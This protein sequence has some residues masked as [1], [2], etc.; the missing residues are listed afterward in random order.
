MSLD[1]Y[2][3]SIGDSG[4]N[5]FVPYLTAGLDG[6]RECLQAAAEAGADAVEVGIPFSDPVMDGPTIQQASDRSL[7][8]GTTPD[9]VIAELARL[10]LPVPAIVMT[11]TNI[12]FHMGYDRFAGSLANAGVG[13][14][15]LADLPLNEAKPWCEA[16]DSADIATI[17]LAA[18][19]SSEDR[20]RAIAER[21]RGFIYAVGLLGVTGERERLADS[22]TVVVSRL[23]AVTDKPVFVGVGISNPD[24]AA[25]ASKVA[26]GV[27]VGSVLVRKMLEGASPED[28]GYLV[29]EF[30]MVLD[31]YGGHAF[32]EKLQW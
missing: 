19:T 16:A 30:R 7:A 3:Q 32:R 13:G 23:K 4:R 5:C 29:R 31:R 12:A 21:S 11:Y 20:C 18:P 14:A 2:F 8:A 24:Q 10:S 22:A 1:S 15:I 25:E 26:D 27:V 28:I 6:W 17:L 9:S